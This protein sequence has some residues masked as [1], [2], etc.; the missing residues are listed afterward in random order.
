ME[1]FET[2]NKG[3]IKF[4]RRE[5]LTQHRWMIEVDVA[6]PAAD[7][8]AGVEIFY[9]TDANRFQSQSICRVLLRN[10]EKIKRLTQTPYN[11]L[12]ILSRADQLRLARL[13]GSALAIQMPIMA[14][15]LYWLAARFPDSVFESG[16]GLLLGRGCSGH[17]E[18]FFLQNCAVQIVHS[19]AE[20]HLCER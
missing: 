11:S 20:R 17:V 15:A 19:V 1:K 10:A 2:G 16:N 3:D 8:W 4:T 5:S 12:F 7:E 14:V 18:D 6:F 13:T 9:A